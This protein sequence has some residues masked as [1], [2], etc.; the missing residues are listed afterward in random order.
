MLQFEWLLALLTG[1]VGLTALARGWK[2]PYPVILA[3]GGTALALFSHG[4]KL[5]LDPSLVLTL[6]VAPV[7]LNS[8]FDLSLRDL[9]K[10]WIPVTCLVVM[11]VAVTAAAVA[12]VTRALVPDMPWAAAIALGAIVA[13]PD[14][15][16]ATAILRQ[17]NLP[18][19][20]LIILEGESLLNDATALLIYRVAVAAF[21]AG[22]FGVGDIVRGLS[23]GVFGSVIAGYVLAWAILELL[24]RVEDAPSSTVLQLVGTFG[25]W[26]LADRL[27]LSPIVT[28]VVFAFTMAQL[29]PQ[30]TDARLRVQSFAVWGTAAFVFTVLAFV[31]IGMQLRPIVLSL[32]PEQRYRYLAVAGAVLATAILVRFFWLAAYQLAAGLKL[33]YLGAGHW[34]GT[35]APTWKG[36]VLA[37]W[38]GMRG[39]VTLATA[40]ALPVAT[41]K[42]LAFPYRDLILLCA[43]G[44]VVGTLVIHGLTLRPLLLLMKLKPDET[45]RREVLVAEQELRS[46]ALAE[47]EVD[48]T[49]EALA[50]RRQVLSAPQLPES[51][52]P[53]PPGTLRDRLIQRQRA[54]LF[55][56]RS[57]SV[58]GDDAFHQV[59]E[60]LDLAEL[61][62]SRPL[63]S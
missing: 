53:R 26:I 13:P 5:A 22:S 42:T 10:Q 11:V 44:V 28:V 45:V 40:Y 17:M 25:V 61:S 20:L 52:E 18:H 51:D 9:K 2:L 57:K 49:P 50:L 36:T 54:A 30:R 37:S 39:I 58:I 21:V 55:E 8:A 38:S 16:A 47:L 23:L 4:P 62:A 56:L 14:A 48:G 46:V 63:L 35:P 12:C 31:L 1:A 34:P 43:F 15:S 60:R 24:S 27:D 59:E 33:R 7:L 41:G 3:L 29:A 19:R 32:A 6:F